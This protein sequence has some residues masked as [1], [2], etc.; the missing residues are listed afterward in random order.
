MSVEE[1]EIC[2]QIKNKYILN[3]RHVDKYIKRFKQ[4]HFKRER[5]KYASR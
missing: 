2:A 1:E 3:F 5:R 4:I